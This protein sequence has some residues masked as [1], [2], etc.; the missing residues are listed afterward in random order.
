MH[1]LKKGSRKKPAHE[2]GADSEVSGGWTVSRRYFSLCPWDYGVRVLGKMLLGIVESLILPSLVPQSALLADDRAS[3]NSK[4]GGAAGHVVLDVDYL[5]VFK[6][7][8]QMCF[9][10]T[11]VF[12]MT[13]SCV[14]WWRQWGEGGLGILLRV[15]RGWE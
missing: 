10:E 12:L 2:L 4:E 7:T 3:V 13:F 1:H 11:A 6:A 9:V 14:S 5:G 8:W 15:K